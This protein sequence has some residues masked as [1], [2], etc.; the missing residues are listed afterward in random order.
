[1]SFDIVIASAL[2]S[3]KRPVNPPR[4]ITSG[5]FPTSDKESLQIKNINKIKKM[6][7]TSLEK[8]NLI[9]TNRLMLTIFGQG[10]EKEFVKL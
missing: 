10:Q 5:S 1:M 4:A 8:Q 6:D 2:P 3:G 7:Q 9:V